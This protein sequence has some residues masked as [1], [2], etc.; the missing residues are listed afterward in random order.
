[1]KFILKM[2]FCLVPLAIF[3]VAS[4]VVVTAYM[5]IHSKKLSKSVADEN[6]IFLEA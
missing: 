6:E 3:M 2:V 4:A 5:L 1:M